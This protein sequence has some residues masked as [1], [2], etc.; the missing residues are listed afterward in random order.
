MAMMT[1][2]VDTS[3]TKAQRAE[4]LKRAMNPWEA[5]DEVRAIARNGRAGLSP[6]WTSTY[7]KW[8]GIVSQG[9][10]LG[11][12]GG[13][14]G[15]GRATDYFMMRIGVPNGILSAVQLRAIGGLARRHARNLADI[16]GRQ[17]IQLR[18]LTLESLPEVVDTLQAAGLT[19]RSS[20]GDAAAN[21]TGCPLAGVAAD[22]LIDASPLALEVA[23]LLQGNPEF[24]NLPR[25]LKIS[26][27]GCRSWCS[28]PEINDIALT[29]TRHN[30]Q[31]GY[32][33]RVGGGLSKEP[34]FALR[35][36]A[37]L[38]P[39]QAAHAVRVVAEIFRDQHS[40]RLNRKAARMKYLFL[41][42]GWTA[43]SF[44][45]E[46]QSRLDFTL[47]PGAPEQ[48]PG[49]VVRD[50]VGIHPQHQPGLSSVGATVLCG[51]LSADQMDA[52]ADL[53]ERFG[54]GALRTTVSQNLLFLDIPNHRT[55]EL[56]RELERIGLLVEVS[57]FRRSAVACT[58][59]EFCK[60]AITETKA[61]TR[62]LMDR[63]DERFPQFDQQLR[64]AATG[65]PN[66][67]AHHWIA[68]IGLEG[69]KIKH[70]GELADAYSF[71][72]GGALGEHASFAR[73]V[74]YRCAAPQVPDAM[75][76]L[77]RHYLAS[78]HPGENLRAWFS[79][80]SDSYLRACLASAAQPPIETKNPVPGAD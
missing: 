76:R 28:D 25:K 35:L 22:E 41:K 36:D 67:C 9:D 72:L 10:G 8:W 31:T 59:A 75:E 53:A 13:T 77:L 3:E 63:L 44:L 55:A 51:R 19:P 40:L 2:S 18:W 38:L 46:L 45:A 26:I 4:R 62:E 56:A 52:A 30:G 60:L 70:K 34:H 54:S 39:D 33:I 64:L 42:E 5:F 57:P 12:T 49:D 17:A 74:G 6:A 43:Q 71:C 14:E 24:Y 32:S 47:L 65:C 78:R 73:P 79:R 11:A 80:H 37:F 1:Q 7:L 20:S 50:H 61:F 27:T 23:H 48:V 21:V 16:S 68:D 15:E 58:G 29:A 66:G 69:R